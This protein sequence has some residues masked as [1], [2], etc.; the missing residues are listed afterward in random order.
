MIG[1]I[2]S[3]EHLERWFK[4][5]GEPYFT[6]KYAGP[7]ERVIFRNDGAIEDIET[8]WDELRHQ[9]EMQGASGRAMLEVLAYKKGRNNHALR[10][11]VDIRAVTTNAQMAGINGMPG[12]MSSM[13]DYVD[14]KVEL[15][16][17]K[18]D[19]EEL[20]FRLME[21][22]NTWERIIDKVSE[23]PHLA[24]IA[25]MLIANLTKTGNASQ[26]IAQ[27]PKPDVEQPQHANGNPNHQFEQNILDTSR[28]LEM[29][30][31]TL[32]AKLKRL[33][34]TNPDLAKQILNESGNVS[35]T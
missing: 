31:V 6:L 29:D 16:M 5:N 14:M 11:N 8:A 25:Q 15:A 28:M 4:G 3:I 30:H 18:R 12:S 21:P 20:E 34:E 26:Q 13:V 19:N 27:Q 9:V 23:S 1:A 22:A 32:S 7:G 10:T 35:N 2:T 24:G 33:V 17:L